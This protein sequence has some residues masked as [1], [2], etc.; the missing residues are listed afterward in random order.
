MPYLYA[1][2]NFLF[3]SLT[4]LLYHP[5]FPTPLLLKQAH[6]HAFCSPVCLA[7]ALPPT[8]LA[9]LPCNSLVCPACQKLGSKWRQDA[10]VDGTDGS[11]RRRSASR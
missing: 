7:L 5:S 10:V 11:S 8:L 1:P 6:S 4:F 9:C 3:V 2:F